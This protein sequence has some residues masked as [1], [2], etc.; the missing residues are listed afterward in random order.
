MLTYGSSFLRVLVFLILSA[1]FLLPISTSLWAGDPWKDKPWTEWTKKEARQI[2]EKSPWAKKVE[3]F[4]HIPTPAV[5]QIADFDSTV[6]W[7]SSRTIR[8][9]GM[10]L[11]GKPSS[12]S[13]ERSTQGLSRRPEQYI[14]WV[15]ASTIPNARNKRY[16]DG[17][18]WFSLLNDDDRRKSVYLKPKHS[19]QKVFPVRVEFRLG[20][21]TQAR[22]YF[23]RELDGEPLIGPKEKKVEFV[24]RVRDYVI[25]TDFNLR[26]MV[27]DGKPDL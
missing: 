27:R 16:V 17:M 12:F 25:R 24:W 26:K 7:S 6:V 18:K 23:P 11:S 2:Q 19:K 10:R 5:V 4:S 15:W 3:F 21:S 13:V 20:G 14:I 22:F 1:L 9:S 8:E